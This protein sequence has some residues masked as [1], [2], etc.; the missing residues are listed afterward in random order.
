MTTHNPYP[1]TIH[2][3]SAQ[4]PLTRHPS[5][6]AISIP[7]DTPNTFIAPDGQARSLQELGICHLT[8]F[9][10]YVNDFGLAAINCIHE[11]GQLLRS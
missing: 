2:T 9:T 7:A 11:Y 3:S 1:Y 4:P 5:P 8:N 10:V 6:P